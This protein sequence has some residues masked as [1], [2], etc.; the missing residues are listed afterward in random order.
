MSEINLELLSQQIV[1]SVD[2][3]IYKEWINDEEFAQFDEVEC[4]LECLVDTVQENFAD[5][6]KEAYSD[7]WRECNDPHEHLEQAW[8]VSRVKRLIGE[9]DNAV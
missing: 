9:M 2:Y 7:G 3:D 6:L 5:Q 4:M 1:E 8:E